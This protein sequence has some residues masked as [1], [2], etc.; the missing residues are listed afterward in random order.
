M[1][2]GRAPSP[3]IRV[4]KAAGC[5]RCRQLERWLEQQRLPYLA[6]DVERNRRAAREFQ[7]YGGRGVPLVVVGEEV[8][9]GFHPQRILRRLG[10]DP[11]GG[12]RRRPSP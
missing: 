7:R 6:L 4:Y 9:Q 10:R 3:R 12:G 11:R 5:G 8:I 2:K 1:A